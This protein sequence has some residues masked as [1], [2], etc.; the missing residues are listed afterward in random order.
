VRTLILV[1]VAAL[2][3]CG[4]GS[5][6]PPTTP[7]AASSAPVADVPAAPSAAPVASA[8]APAPPVDD[9]YE[10]VETDPTTLT[11]L[12]DK[13]NRP[14]FP[15]A[16]AS[17]ATCWQTIG[18]SG[19]AE[20]DYEVLASKCGTPTGAV[21]YVKP[22]AGRLHSVKDKR[23]TYKLHLQ[24]GLCYRY[25]GVADG[26]VKDLD[27]LILQRGA[28]VGDDKANGP[29]AIIE[30]DK[31]W[32]QDKDVDYDFGVEVDGTGTGKYVFG[33]WAQPK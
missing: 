27:I 30:S 14:T 29:V 23:D 20:K 28:L 17:P 13:S 19:N 8:A 12:F 22:A 9:K 31:T 16:T 7:A 18:L 1:P 11:P 4:G 32:C 2:L 5:P 25:F 15:K 21:A 24:G 33:V 6:P 26:T 3:A 10:D